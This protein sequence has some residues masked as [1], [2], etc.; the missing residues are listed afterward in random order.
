MSAAPLPDFEDRLL[1]ER[2][3]K[4]GSGKWTVSREFRY[5][6]AVLGREVVVPVGFETDLASVPR[7]PVIFYLT[8]ATCD[9][10]AVIHDYLYTTKEVTRA[11]ADAVLREAS[12]VM[13]TPSWRSALMWLGV[14]VGGGAYWKEPTASLP[15][16]LYVG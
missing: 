7:L 8:G 13:G 1:L 11:Q 16:D 4:P 9:E 6:S 2:S 15:D 14:R 10:A 5:Y 3:G 12:G